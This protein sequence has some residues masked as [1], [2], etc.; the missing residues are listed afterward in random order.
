MPRAA[1][2]LQETRQLKG[3]I[4]CEC[5]FARNVFEMSPCDLTLNLPEG[6]IIYLG[7]K[8]YVRFKVNGKICSNGHDFDT[9]IR[10]HRVSPDTGYVVFQEYIEDNT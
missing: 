10:K 9:P 8:Q 2:L 6:H 5:R 1:K 7:P 3:M 4:A